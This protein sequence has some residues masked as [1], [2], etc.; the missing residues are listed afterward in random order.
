MFVE[1]VESFIT[2]EAMVAVKQIDF[3]VLIDAGGFIYF[4]HLLF[5]QQGILDQKAF[6]IDTDLGEKRFRRDQAVRFRDIAQ[7]E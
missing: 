5:A 1:E 2:A 7:T 4:F 3:V 6:V